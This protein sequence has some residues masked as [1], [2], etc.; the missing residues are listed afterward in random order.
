MLRSRLEG[1]AHLGTSDQRRQGG[2]ADRA[3][4]QWGTPSR[5]P[6][7]CRT[8]P[9]DDQV[10]GLQIVLGCVAVRHDKTRQPC[11]LSRS[12][13][14]GRVLDRNDP[15]WLED[16]APKDLEIHR[17]VGFETGDLRAGQR[18]LER[19]G[20]EVVMEQRLDPLPAARG[21]DEES[22]SR[23]TQLVDK[24]AYP[25]S[26]GD[27]TIARKSPVLARC[28]SSA[29]RVAASASYP[30]DARYVR[31]SLLPSRPCQEPAVG[32]GVPAVRKPG[33]GECLVE[34]HPVT[35]AFAV[36]KGPVDIEDDRLQMAHAALPAAS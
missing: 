5:D 16:G 19:G 9:V 8:E 3:A 10:S 6:L 32:V 2:R 34:C 20:P 14:V 25:G 22:D 35:I 1:P 15:G 30:R 13:P 24:S 4:R 33:V 11:R 23:Q 7:R 26:Q 27:T 28:R 18:Q 12:E 29:S 36:R 21:G 17:G 31:R